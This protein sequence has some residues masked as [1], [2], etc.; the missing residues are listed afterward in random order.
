M[1][2][3]I[4]L[5]IVG[6]GRAG[7]GMHCEELAGKESMFKIVAGCDIL[8]KRR[9]AMGKRYGCPAYERVEDLIADPNVELVS[10][11]TRS[12]DHFAHARMALRAGKHVFLEKPICLTYKEAKALM[13][14][15]D[16][17]TGTLYVRHNRRFEPAFLHIREILASGIL[18]EVFEIK[19]ARLGYSRRNDWQALKA[20]GGGQLL[21]WGPH[22]IDHAL[23]FLDSP[24]ASVWCDLKCVAAAGDAEDHV[25]L[26][27]RGANGRVVDVEIS[28]GAA[29]DLPEYVIW[30][31]RGGLEAKGDTISLRYLDPRKRLPQRKADPG[32]PD[33]KW[34]SPD[35]LKWIEK[36]LTVSPSE[37]PDIWEKLYRSIRYDR[38]FPITN[39]HA[40]EVMR[41]VSLAKAGTGF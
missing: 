11:A 21:N 8:R 22:L 26:V 19:L 18:G 28:G 13:K 9:V 29:V 1:K 27:L 10:I 7:W 4:A 6:L 24:V 32:D 39:D 12:P 3:P 5:G 15:A 2:K 34:G 14:E 20:C 37:Q 40:L 33:L 30:G 16:R 38:P 41:V 17:S 23:L 25:K 35:A 31:S 36:T